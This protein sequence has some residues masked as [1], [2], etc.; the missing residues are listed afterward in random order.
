MGVIGSALVPGVLARVS[1]AIFSSAT[2]N[3]AALIVPLSIAIISII[4]IAVISFLIAKEQIKRI[5]PDKDDFV[6]TETPYDKSTVYI[7]SI[8]FSLFL[9]GVSIA[10]Y[11]ES[12]AYY[13]VVT[14][15]LHAVT[16]SLLCMYKYV[17][18]RYTRIVL[19]LSI[20][21]Q[22]FE[23]IILKMDY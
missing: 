8:V 17:L 6:M 15:N 9:Y 3:L 18:S 23:S 16:V 10:L 12:W 11:F 4:V 13:H 19:A 7:V 20:L 21:Y 1:I 14:T 22:L 5:R 2:Y